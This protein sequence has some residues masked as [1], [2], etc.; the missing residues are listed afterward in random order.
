M[1]TL[2]GDKELLAGL[3][4]V[5]VTEV[6]DGEGSATAGVVDDVLHH[7]LKQKTHFGLQ[8]PSLENGD[9]TFAMIAVSKNK[10]TWADSS[11]LLFFHHCSLMLSSLD[12][13][14]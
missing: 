12:P 2:G 10:I 6:D 14:K 4:P 9:V 11:E 5:R 3:V 13:P 8:N 1:D 7:T